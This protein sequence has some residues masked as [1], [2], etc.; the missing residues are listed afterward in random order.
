MEDILDIIKDMGKT[1]NVVGADICGI[2]Y[3]DTK[4][5]RVVSRIHDQLLRAMS[6]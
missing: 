6:S 4:T 2:E 5:L 1:F 3:Y